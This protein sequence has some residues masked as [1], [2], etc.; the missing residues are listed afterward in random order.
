MVMYI[1]NGDVYPD[2]FVISQA[3]IRVICLCIIVII[4]NNSVLYV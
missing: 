4:L 2:S 1:P 3:A